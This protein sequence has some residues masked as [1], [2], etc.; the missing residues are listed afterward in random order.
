LQFIA[1]SFLDFKVLHWLAIQ[2]R[3]ESN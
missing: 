2:S 3:L 1:V